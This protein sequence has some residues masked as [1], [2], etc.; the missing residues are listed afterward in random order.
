MY[1]MYVQYNVTMYIYNIYM[2]MVTQQSTTYYVRNYTRSTHNDYTL[3][4]ILMIRR[5]YSFGRVL[6]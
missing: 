4:R 5:S 6:T 1:C 2:F 3:M